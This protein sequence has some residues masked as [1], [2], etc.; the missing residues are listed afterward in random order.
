MCVV[1]FG[2]QWAAMVVLLCVGLLPA[3]S[4]AKQVSGFIEKVVIYPGNLEMKAKI[5]T[6]AFSTSLHCT[7]CDKTYQKDGKEWV[8]FTVTNWRGESI[9]LER[10]VVGRTNITRHFGASQDRLVITLPVCLGGVLKE[11]KVNVVDRSGFNYQ[12]LVGRNFLKGDFVVDPDE[13]YQLS[14]TCPDAA[15][16][17]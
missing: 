11:R 12:M 15:P 4:F 14:Q 6:G 9:E 5:D 1:S 8:R 16:S 10:E 13:K 2:R 17:N 7:T 3:V